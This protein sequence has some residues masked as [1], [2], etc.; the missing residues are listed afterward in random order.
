MTGDSS[1][2]G[3]E[4][5]AVSGTA[6]AWISTRSPARLSQGKLYT[7]IMGDVFRFTRDLDSRYVVETFV[8]GADVANDDR[9]VDAV[10][11]RLFQGATV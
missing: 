7:G 5:L 3:V 9:S 2:K 1:V 8:P 10:L 6:G 4:R 11:D